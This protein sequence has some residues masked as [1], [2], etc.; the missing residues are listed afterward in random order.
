MVADASVNSTEAAAASSLFGIGV[1][2]ADVGL[3]ILG[4]AALR[5]RVWPPQ[6]AAL[7]LALGA[8]QLLIVTPVVLTAGF[9]SAASLVVITLQDVLVASIGCALIARASGGATAISAEPPARPAT[10]ASQRP[11]PTLDVDQRVAPGSEA[12]TGR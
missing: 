2:F 8:F 12:R 6:W 9:A 3:I 10:R 11:V 4:W 5:A 1:I 7:P